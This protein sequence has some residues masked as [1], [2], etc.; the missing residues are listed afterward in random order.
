MPLYSSPSLNPRPKRPDP[1]ALKWP[2][3]PGSSIPDPFTGGAADPDVFEPMQQQFAQAL[4]NLG[5]APELD[6]DPFAD[7][8][9]LEDE[10]LF[11]ALPE[12]DEGPDFGAIQYEGEL[13]PEGGLWDFEAGQAPE[14]PLISRLRE[15]RGEAPQP[16]PSREGFFEPVE[17]EPGGV[18]GAE[19]PFGISRFMREQV[20]PRF[21]AA[22][23]A[24]I[25][26]QPSGVVTRAL[27][28][29]QGRVLRP[30][31]EGL[32]P[33]TAEEFGLELLP[34]IG[35]VPGAASA[36]R[37]FGRAG[38]REIAGR[39]P[40][41]YYTGIFPEDAAAIAREGLRP[42]TALTR[43][44]GVAEAYAASR[45]RGTG[46]DPETLQFRAR[47]RDLDEAPYYQTNRERLFL[48][49][50]S[51][52]ALEHMP[53]FAG[54]R[55]GAGIPPVDDF[56]KLLAQSLDIAK[57][58]KT[59]QEAA[60]RFGQE[61]RVFEEGRRA[62]SAATPNPFR[63]TAHL[64]KRATKLSQAMDV[65]KGGE[66]GAIKLPENGDEF[67]HNFVEGLSPRRIGNEL[68]QSVAGLDA[69]NALRHGWGTIRHGTEYLASAKSA[70]R[71]GLDEAYSASRHA[72]LV[73]KERPGRFISDF[74]GDLVKREEQFA[75]DLVGNLPGY[76][77]TGRGNIMFINEQRAHVYDQV[78][79]AWRQS[80]ARIE[81]G[82]AG[83]WQRLQAKLAR[84]GD[85]EA[86]GQYISRNTGRGTLGPLEGTWV[87]TALGIGFFSPRYQASRL[88]GPLQML[89]FKHP[90]V[91]MEA[92]K[93]FGASTAATI[94]L[95]ALANES[96]LAS[97]NLNPLSSDFGQFKVGDTRIDPWAGFRPLVTLAA[98]LWAGHYESGFGVD[99][100][101]LLKKF[102]RSKASPLAGKFWDVLEGEDFLGRP[103]TPEMMAT[104]FLPIFAQGLYEASKEGLL[105]E[106][107]ASLPAS[108]F[109]L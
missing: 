36:G 40:R 38:A 42:G 71:A 103:V 52:E 108:F 95:L 99:A 17:P 77:Q 55:F 4:P 80:A 98:R 14:R 10:D 69:S 54:A 26:A 18:H 8:P 78:E 6:Y 94:S 48:P 33:V 101:E 85:L 43:D 109:G 50:S 92:I 1:Y 83:P 75:G 74:A 82:T 104:G 24:G 45:A 62:E 7:L 44:R 39:I 105:G 106:A 102:V 28:L 13:A 86:L 46:L 34:G 5:T 100:P 11:A 9:E 60:T 49:G 31:A 63:D 66:E 25:N 19:L 89:N 27:G 47:P 12:L 22:F 87:D 3:L 67:V 32:V 56:E 97:V 61:A 65:L 21:G 76:K 88:Q 16:V 41:S 59:P 96:G 2:T 15:R 73:A 81:E 70:V 90:L 107:L 57:Q 37:K 91:A 30:F 64:R 35:T 72:E 51:A 29:N 93:D 84:E 53:D 20:Q 68:R 23:E 79:G 58:A